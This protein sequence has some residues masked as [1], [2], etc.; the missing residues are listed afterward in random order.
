M[1]KFRNLSGQRFGSLTVKSAH[2]ERSLSGNIRWFCRC[3]CGNDR[4]VVGS[5]LING[6]TK[7]CGCWSREKAKDL[8]D[9][10]TGLRFGRLV[11]VDRCGSDK[12]GRAKW[13][14]RCDCGGETKSMGFTLRGGKAKSCGCISSEVGRS[15]TKDVI[16]QR[17]GMLLV[18]NRVIDAKGRGKWLCKCDCGSEALR[19]TTVLT[20]GKTIS[21]GCA[22]KTNNQRPPFAPEKVRAKGI[23]ESAK[24]RAKIRKAGGF[25]TA[26]QINELYAKQRGKCANCGCKLMDAN[27]AR[28]HRHPLAKGGSNDISN[29]ELLCRPCNQ[30][31]SAK[32]PLQWANE[33]GRLL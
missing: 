5:E 19:S 11:V 20:T 2:P 12:R 23:S 13:L 6:H 22:V 16:G 27:M 30:R 21:C 10:L 32:D 9:D 4:V 15:K 1:G 31:K 17:F 24:R 14:C 28:D 18:K 25:F 26:F 8:C 7:S 29:I 33:N 3:D